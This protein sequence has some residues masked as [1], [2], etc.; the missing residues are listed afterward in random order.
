M[1]AAVSSSHL[2]SAPLS[3]S[4]SSHTAPACV[5]PTG[6][7]SSPTV[8]AWVPSWGAVLQEQTAPAWVPCGVKSPASKRAPVWAP[9]SLGGHG[10]SCRKPAPMQALRGVAA[11]S[12]SSGV[13]SSMSCRW[14]SAPL[15]TSTGC[16]GI[17]ALVP[18]APPPLSFFTDLDVCRVVSCTCFSLLSPAVIA[19][20]FFPCLNTL[21]QKQY[22]RC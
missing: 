22:Y 19:Q 18:G 13:E 1:G 2:V 9:L 5:P 12:R 17:S 6:C 21:S 4:H 3:S 20:G 11:S 7:S 10:R 15:W 16:R 14:R 8:P